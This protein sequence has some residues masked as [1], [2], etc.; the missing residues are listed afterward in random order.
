MVPCLGAEAATL[1]DRGA[2]PRPRP[3]FGEEWLVAVLDSLS[4]GVVALGVD[5]TLTAANPAAERLLGFSIGEV[6]FSSWDRFAWVRLIDEEGAEL[7]AERHP[8]AATLRERRSREPEVVGIAS[9]DTIRWIELATHVFDTVGEQSTGGVV[10]VLDDVTPRVESE[11]ERRRLV[12]LLRDV[13][14]G[15]TH[16]V[17]SPLAV[18]QAQVDHLARDWHTLTD[19]DRTRAFEVVG[20]RAREIGRVIGDLATMSQLEGGAVATAAEP[21]SVEALIAHSLDGIASSRREDVEVA[22]VPNLSVMVDPDHGRRMLLNLLENALKY[23]APPVKVSVRAVAGHV[24]FRISDEGEGV[25]E[26]L[27]GR[28]FERFTRGGSTGDVSGMGLGLAIVD[29]LARLHGG[30]V[31]YDSDTGSGARFDLALPVA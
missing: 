10:V 9:G 24:V 13:M 11:R 1:S 3:R 15:A 25:P 14:A 6:R 20:R 18:V 29:R 2:V 21:T 27:T 26:E 4:E 12:E 22:D 16:D 19:E 8:V 5:G 17:R 7:T 31:T 30:E 23:G 28:L